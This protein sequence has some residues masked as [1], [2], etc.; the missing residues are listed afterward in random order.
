MSA[1]EIARARA[2][3]EAARERLLT[4]AHLLQARLKP[5]VL[6]ADAWVAAREK[7]ETAATQAV[8]AVGQRPVA[9]S[10]A[11]VGLAALLARKPIARLVQRLRG[12]HQ[13]GDE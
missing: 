12:K 8:R 4:S 9:A 10:A 1:A 2:D 3:A 6:A 5:S 7:G 13:D 11:L